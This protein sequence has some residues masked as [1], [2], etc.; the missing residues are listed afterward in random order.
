MTAYPGTT[1]SAAPPARP[2]LRQIAALP[3]PFALPLLGNAL[4]LKPSRVHRDVEDWCRRYGPLFRIRLGRSKVLVVA[5]HEAVAAV[6]RDRPDGFRRP[7]ATADLS[8]EMGGVPG[9]F[10]VEG[11]EWRN[12]RRVVMQGFAPAAIKAYFPSLVAVALRLQRRWDAAAGAGA[13]IDL[14][15]DLKRYTVDI[16]AGLA[17]GTDVNTIESGGDVI[18]RHLDVM[19]P[20]LARRSLALWP[21]W[22]YFKLPA[23]RRLERSAV[24]LRA[25]IGDLV[26]QAR[27]RLLAEPARRE[28]PPNLLEAMLCAADQAGS[29]VDDQAVGGNVLTMLLAGEDTTANTISWMLYLLQR[30][31]RALRRAQ[32]EV[33][34]LAPDP[35]AF[36]VEQMDAL[37]YLGACASE[38]MRLKPVAPYMPLEALRDSVVGDVAVPAGSYVW[39]VLRHDSVADAHVPNA[40]AFEPQRWLAPAHGE[41][42]AGFDKQLALPF[43]AGLRTCPGRY[44]ALLE[45]KG[46]VAMLLARFEL[47]GVDTPDG[48]EARELMAFVMSPVGLRMRLR[49]LAA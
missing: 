47:L 44:L 48:G 7:K 6:L 29:G 2:A 46:A 12:Q 14:A 49:A 16:I 42:G 23:D 17:F 3:G 9:L 25:A 15:D 13:A 35:A 4:Q 31:P 10:M 30:H 37:D 20:A 41:A 22:R 28:R 1:P 11:A 24:A 27:Q 32:D 18:Q 8:L 40:A 33:R 45:M 39:C 5:G 21:Y 43:G 19:L 38:A 36:S 26:G 34:R